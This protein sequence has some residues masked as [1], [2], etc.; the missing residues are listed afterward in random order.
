MQEMK[1]ERDVLTLTD[2]QS[3]IKAIMNNNIKKYQ[4]R[5]IWKIK[6]KYIIL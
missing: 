4:N 1:I 2:S 3:V 5:Y 6:K